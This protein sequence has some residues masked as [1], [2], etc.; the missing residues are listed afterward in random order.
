MP[1]P[2]D[3]SLLSPS[4]RFFIGL[5]C[6]FEKKGGTIPGFSFQKNKKE[7]VVRVAQYPGAP[8]RFGVALY[9]DIYGMMTATLRLGPGDSAEVESYD[10]GISYLLYHSGS[11]LDVYE[12]SQ[13]S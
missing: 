8:L 7:W 6:R 5:Y 3:P 10:E 9:R 13:S 11:H 4:G 12:L 2:S 1:L